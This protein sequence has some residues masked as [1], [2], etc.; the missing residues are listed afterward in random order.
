[1]K[2]DGY[3]TVE[4][5]FVMTICIVILMAVLYTGLYV[6]DRMVLETV[7]QRV[8]SR[9]IHMTDRKKWDENTFR[10]KLNTELNNKLFL[11]PV[12]DIRV[13]NSL[14]SKKVSVRYSL[15]ISLGFLK[16][17][18]GGETGEREETVHVPDIWPAKWKWDADAI[19]GKGGDGHDSGGVE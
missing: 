18:W 12:H 7:S 14:T 9:W 6:H 1:M 2:K 17:I 15:P 11:L 4:A 5:T 8:T 13:S 3:Y 10:E 16:R 19:K